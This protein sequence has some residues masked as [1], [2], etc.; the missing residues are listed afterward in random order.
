MSN[1]CSHAVMVFCP[2]C[3]YQNT[4]QSHKKKIAL[5]A[6]REYL[7]LSL[8]LTGYTLIRKM[9]LLIES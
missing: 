7:N 8:H 2:F 4:Y 6:V 5:K 1:Y 3:E 9:N